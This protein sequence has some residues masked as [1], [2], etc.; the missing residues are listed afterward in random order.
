M[1]HVEEVVALSITVVIH[2]MVGVAHLRL[3]TTHW[4][5]KVAHLAKEVAQLQGVVSWK[6]IG[7]WLRAMD[8][9]PL[10]PL[11]PPLVLRLVQ[12]NA[13]MS[14][15]PTRKSLAYPT[16]NMGTDLDVH[17]KVF[18]KAIKLMGKQMI[19]T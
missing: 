4:A 11:I 7:K 1:A 13:T 12:V 17:V 9:S 18:W 16:F 2:V 8:E 6:S 5:V 19:Q 10:E 14:V 15:P 3:V